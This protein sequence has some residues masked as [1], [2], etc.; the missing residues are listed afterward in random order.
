MFDAVLE[1]ASRL[2]YRTFWPRFCAGFVDGIVFLPLSLFLQWLSPRVPTGALALL[3]VVST[4]TGL[5]Y[6]VLL[7]GIYGAT[8]GKMAM[9]VKVLD[10]SEARL[11]MRQAFLR[12]S[13]WIILTIV[14]VV[15]GLR[16]IA[17]GG[18]PLRPQEALAVPAALSAVSLLWFLAEMAT[19]LLNDKRRALHDWIAGSVVVRTR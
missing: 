9:G 8:L 5:A 13:P 3:Y 12:D 11:S 19:M 4:M 14:E 1:D 16:V 10:V 7:H 2:K 15:F 18:N 17:Q 6:N